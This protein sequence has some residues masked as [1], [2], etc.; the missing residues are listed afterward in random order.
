MAGFADQVDDCPAILPSLNIANIQGNEV[1]SSQST[2]EEER[3]DSSIALL[4]KRFSISSR[5]ELFALSDAE[6]I[7]NAPAE[8]WHSLDTPVARDQFWAL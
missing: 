6:P 1:R 2:A 4:P 7:A 8:L 5:E 3:D